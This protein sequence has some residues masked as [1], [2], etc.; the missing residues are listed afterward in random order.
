[1]SPNT[2][3]GMRHVS[4][5]EIAAACGSARRALELTGGDEATALY[6]LH[7]PEGINRV[8]A[9]PVPQLL[10]ALGA[11][12]RELRDDEEAAARAKEK[13]DLL[14]ELQRKARDAWAGKKSVAAVMRACDVGRVTAK[15]LVESVDAD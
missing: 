10:T 15:R 7:N 11:G 4:A 6:L 2:N 12:L 1:M 14:A 13:A 3:Y 5:Q 8:V 9:K